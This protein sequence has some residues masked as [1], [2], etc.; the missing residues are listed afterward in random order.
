MDAR[1]LPAAPAPKT[2]SDRISYVTLS[3]H[4]L[5]G[6]L[7]IPLASRRTPQRRS[8]RARPQ[9]RPR[10]PAMGRLR[11]SVRLR[12]RPAV[13]AGQSPRLPTSLTQRCRTTSVEARPTALLLMVPPSPWLPLTAAT[14]VWTRFLEGVTGWNAGWIQVW[15]MNRC[16]STH[17]TRA[18]LLRQRCLSR[19]VRVRV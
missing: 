11:L 19:A 8:R 17:T 12:R 3:M 18:T 2:L 7:T 9:M 5:F 4:T 15:P 1:N 10:L 13:L 16:T 14:L 6:P